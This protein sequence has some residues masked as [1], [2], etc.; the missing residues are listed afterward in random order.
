M[1][2]KRRP[3]NEDW[4]TKTLWSK[5]KTHWSK[6]KTHQSKTFFSIR[7]RGKDCKREKLD[8][9]FMSVGATRVKLRNAVIF[10][11]QYWNIICRD[12][13]LYFVVTNILF[14]KC[15]SENYDKVTL[16]P[17]YILSL[18]YFLIVY[19]AMPSF[20]QLIN[21]KKCT[22]IQQHLSIISSQI[23][24]PNTLPAGTL[25]PISLI[26]FL[27]SAYFNL[28]SIVT[29]QPAKISSRDYS[30]YSEQ[31]FYSTGSFTTTLGISSFWKPCR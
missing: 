2:L 6:T 8:S 17:C 25:F 18:S 24:S 10:Q 21:R 3:K 4:I 27:D 15:T 5:T 28:Q 20:R 14:W 9:Y 11:Q 7:K 1:C 13:L 30:K 23:S 31:R 26:T 12:D 22:T 29:S 19:R 16:L